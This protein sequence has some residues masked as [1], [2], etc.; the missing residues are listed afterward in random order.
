MQTAAAAAKSFQSCPT[1]WTPETAA[2]QAHLSLGFS[3]QEDP[4]LFPG[5]ER[6]PGEGSGYPLHY[7]CVENPM[8]RGAGG[9][10]SMG[11][12]RFR[13]DWATNI[14]TFLSLKLDNFFC[15]GLILLLLDFFLTTLWIMPV[16]LVEFSLSAE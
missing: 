13:H 11:S 2:H 8:D 4:G 14:F 7:S 1:L 16:L 6:S 12:Q 9:L 15:T 10:Q 3:R 5:S